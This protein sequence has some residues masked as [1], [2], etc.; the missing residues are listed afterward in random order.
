M[1]KIYPI[2]SP[3]RLA[4]VCGVCAVTPRPG[5]LAYEMN[6]GSELIGVCQFR[7]TDTGGEV[8]ELTLKPGADDDEA[9]IILGNAVLSFMLRCGAPTARFLTPDGSRIR[10]LMAAHLDENAHVN[11]AAYLRCKGDNREAQYP[12][13]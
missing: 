7:L 5:T 6:E 9:L 13:V 10:T 3:E 11:L 1:L 8:Y 2:P 12:S 4:E